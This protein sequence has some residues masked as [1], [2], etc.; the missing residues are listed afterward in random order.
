MLIRLCAN[1]PDA[2][3]NCSVIGQTSP[4]VVN[5]G[6]SQGDIGNVAVTPGAT[7]WIQFF[8]PQPYGNGWVAYWWAGGSTISTSDQVQAI[9]LGY[10]R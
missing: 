7:Y 3:G 8:P 9:V 5:Y 1:Q 4:A 2:S 10:N 6:N